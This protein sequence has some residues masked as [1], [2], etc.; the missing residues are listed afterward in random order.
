MPQGVKMN[1]LTQ[2]LAAIG[3]LLAAQGQG[4]A[5]PEVPESLKAP[6]GEE[7]ILSAHAT[8]V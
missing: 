4:P 6:V 8:G 3:M 5:R 1:R 2:V 7:V